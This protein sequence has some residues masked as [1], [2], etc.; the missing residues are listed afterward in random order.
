MLH[1]SK[2]IKSSEGSDL[3]NQNIVLCI[4]GSVAA[5]KC[6]ELARKLM[7]QGVEVKVVMSEKATELITP[8]LMHWATGNPVT[9]ELTGAIEHVEL[10]QWGDLVLIAPSTANTLSKVACAVD[11][12][13][14]TSVVSVAQGLKKPI[15]IVPAMHESMYSHKIIQDNLSRL[16]E[17]GIQVLE[18][19]LEEGKAKLPEVEEIV[20]LVKS[21]LHPKDLTGKKVLVTA[22]PTL[23]KIDPVKII[24]NKSSGKMG[25]E[26]ARAAE[27]RGADVTLVYGTGIET[28]P[29]AIKTLRVETTSE[30]QDRIRDE[31]QGNYDVFVSAAAPQDFTVENVS[32]DKLRHSEPINL[33]LVPA[34]RI[35]DE[36]RE[37]SPE[38]FLIGFKAEYEVS[39]EE[40]EK[41]ARG[42][43]EESQLDMV[44]ANDLARSGAGFE[45]STNDVLILSKSDLK[46]VKSSKLAIAHTIFDL[47]ADEL[48]GSKQ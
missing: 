17:A 38:T 15:L 47:V 19:K 48:E 14:V 28:P 29:P 37:R 42:K 39:D 23:E 30:M 6:M 46:R 20:N 2:N 26:I 40:L 43:M 24:T 11:D 22:G 35:V 4:T 7:R 1:P 12:T 21:L 25:I 44:V 10:A 31:L 34:P 16:K 36:V 13:P 3:A 27:M 18:P 32:E 45:S 5:V 8:Q 33:K 41:A 9:T